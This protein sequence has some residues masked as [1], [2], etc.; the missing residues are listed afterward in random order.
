MDFIDPLPHPRVLEH[1]QKE[2]LVIRKCSCEQDWKMEGFRA[3][4]SKQA[5][6]SEPRDPMPL[7]ILCRFYFC[8]V[9]AEGG[10]AGL[11]F[12]PLSQS[13]RTAVLCQHG[14]QRHTWQVSKDCLR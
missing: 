7:L 8:L 10:T 2:A 13:S 4:G 1:C 12:S 14:S 6:N 11:V 9:T 3:V 5:G